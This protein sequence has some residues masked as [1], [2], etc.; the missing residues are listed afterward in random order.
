MTFQPTNPDLSLGNVRPGVYVAVN[1]AAPGGGIGD[2]DR[3]LLLVGYKTSAGTAPQDTI[4]QA[5]AEQD[6]IDGCGRKSDLRR[7]FN[8]AMAQIGPGSVDAF[9]LPLVE[10]SGGQASTYKIIVKAAAAA[11]ASGSV[12]VSIGGRPI[13]SIGF[14]TGDATTSIAQS[15][16]DAINNLDDAPGGAS[17][18]SSTV[19]VTYPHK[20]DVGEDLPI[21]CK[22]NGTGTGITISD[23]SL[24]F[25]TNV[26]G[27]GS[28]RIV[29]GATT[30]TVAITGGDTPAQVATKVV[31]AIAA[32]AYPVTAAIGGTSATVDLF[33]AAGRDVRRITASIVTSTGIT[34]D[35][36]AFGTVGSGAPDLTAALANLQSQG[37]FGSW[38]VPF[39]GTQAT[40]DTTTLGTI[41]TYVEL[42]ADGVHQHEQRV[43]AGAAWPAA[44]FGTI[45]VGTSPALTSSP[46]YAMLWAQDFGIQ[47][48]EIACRIAAA[49]AGNDYAAKN[50]DGYILKG[51]TTAPLVLPAIPSRPIGDTINAA[52]RSYYLTPIRVDNQT[53]TAVIEKGTTTSNSSYL[54]L[55]DFA[56]I[57]QISFW[58]RSVAQRLINL[59]SA[60]SAK[61][62]GTPRT[63]NTITAQAVADAMYLLAL[64]WDSADLY[65]G[66]ETFKAGFTSKFNQVNPTRIDAAFPMSPV[67]NVHQIGVIGNLTSPASV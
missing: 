46:R 12:D 42:Q 65:D 39:V 66:A 47:A 28:V 53:N 29:I 7:G 1:L 34:V 61:Q 20:G 18:A 38:A 59:F 58:R 8:A 22:V 60:V 11:L 13:V 37:G 33:Y 64:E 35:Q 51:S 9:I 4:F 55:R 63:P 26:T 16:N 15:I 62:V 32:G 21:R 49:R 24:V 40:P 36:T 6:V 67:I 27:N 2:I 52:M 5:L 48:W 57:D 44:T 17:I 14:S 19:T 56:T 31:A 50:W 3:R 25:A 45:P 23:G 30:I 41:A 54:P 10:P 43:H